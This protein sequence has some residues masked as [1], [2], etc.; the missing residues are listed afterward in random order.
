MVKRPGQSGFDGERAGYA[1][2]VPE[3]DRDH[4]ADNCDQVHVRHVRHGLPVRS[5]P[6]AWRSHGALGSLAARHQ[7]V[8]RN[9]VPAGRGRRRTRRPPGARETRGTPATRETRGRARARRTGRARPVCT[10]RAARGERGER[11]ERGR[12]P[13]RGAPAG[14][15]RACDRPSNFRRNPGVGHTLCRPAGAG[16]DLRAG[17]GR[18]ALPCG[19]GCDGSAAPVRLLRPPPRPPHAVRGRRTPRAVSAGPPARRPRRGPTHPS[20]D[21]RGTTM[22]EQHTPIRVRRRTTR[23]PARPAAAAAPHPSAA[24]PGRCA[25][26][27]AVRGR[28]PAEG[29][30]ARGGAGQAG[31]AGRVRG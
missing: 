23:H 28:A 15:H 9:R 16:D 27:G 31:R 13:V 11:G 5:C 29:R 10:A 18:V 2:P 24:G 20:T 12:G 8:E 3:C 30:A 19:T 4:S 17:P 7:S 14:G 1:H 25:V 21:Y 6:V 22:S 26:P